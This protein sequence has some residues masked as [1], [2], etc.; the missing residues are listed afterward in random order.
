MN[1]VRE[2]FVSRAKA[3]GPELIFWNW[4]YDG[5]LGEYGDMGLSPDCH[6]ALAEELRAL[7]EEVCSGRLVVVL[8]GGQ[9]RETATYMIPKVISRL[10]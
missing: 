1:L 10:V 5:T 3:F 2:E 8:C 9:G 7:A 6:F 4:G